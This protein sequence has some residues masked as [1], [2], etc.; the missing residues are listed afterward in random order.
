MDQ[1]KNDYA[2][3]ASEDDASIGVPVPLIAGLGN[4]GTIA[5]SEVIASD[6]FAQ[7]LTSDSYC[8]GKPIFEA[9][10]GTDVSGAHAG[11]PRILRE[12]SW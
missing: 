6:A 4:F 8:K 5:A 1:W 2:I 10:I 12:S 9:V 7:E 3:I 11:L